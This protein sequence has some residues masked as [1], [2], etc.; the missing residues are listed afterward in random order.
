MAAATVNDRLHDL[1]LRRH[2][3]VERMK[4]ATA[5][6]INTIWKSATAGIVA[7]VKRAF[8]AKTDAT[9]FGFQRFARH[10][11]GRE[12]IG[13]IADRLSTTSERMTDRFEREL[14]DVI[15]FELL[16]LPRE[17]TTFFDREV[18]HAMSEAM[19]MEEEAAVSLAFDSVPIG[20]V[21]EL[22]TSFLGGARFADSFADLSAATLRSLRTV[23]TTS[24][25]VGHDVRRAAARVQG[26]LDNKRWE[27]ERIVRSEFIRAA[28]QSALITYAQNK[29]Y[30]KAVQWSATFD[31]RTCMQCALLDGRTWADPN[32][33]KI[34]VASTH[35]NC[36]CVLVPVVKSAKD[37]GLPST[38]ATRA[39]FNGQVPASVT[40]KDWFAR[41]TTDFQRDVLGPTRLGLYQSGQ[42]QLKDF[43]SPRGELSV[44]QAL[45]LARRRN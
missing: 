42:L 14:G 1:I 17:I 20:Q 13:D 16:T 32:D 38:P 18:S 12:I 9:G 29:R 45:A 22:F 41:Q 25:F 28:N 24:L 8:P 3:A 4:S 23:L 36:R 39:T 34:P 44:S 43:A 11:T 6:E 37:L 10:T 2:V 7:L 5:R 33:A 15:E 35:P 27:A 19:L 21:R 30:I 31:K 26:V 40:Y